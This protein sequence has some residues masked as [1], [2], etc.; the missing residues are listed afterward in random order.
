[1][2]S[3]RARWATI[4]TI[5]RDELLV[6]RIVSLLNLTFNS[7]WCWSIFCQ[8]FEVHLMR[9]ATL[10]WYVTVHATSMRALV[11]ADAGSRSC[12]IQFLASLS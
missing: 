8:S 2:R 10:R 6:S 11:L 7:F 12:S 3:T 4:F 9:S 1:M 5:A